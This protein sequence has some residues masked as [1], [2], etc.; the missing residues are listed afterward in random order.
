M[1]ELVLIVLVIGM[2][3][4]FFVGRSIAERGRARS[5]MGKIWSGRQGYRK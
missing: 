1:V 3:L 4:G 2:F 5:D